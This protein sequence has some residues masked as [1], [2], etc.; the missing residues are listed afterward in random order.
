MVLKKETKETK[1]E[2]LPS[3]GGG[4]PKLL[5]MSVAR[6]LSIRDQMRTP[7]SVDKQKKCQD[8]QVK[9]K[10]QAFMIQRSSPLLASG[11]GC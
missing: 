4:A 9:Q 1:R 5:W 10:M 3:A 11:A 2:N 7:D 8:G 6:T